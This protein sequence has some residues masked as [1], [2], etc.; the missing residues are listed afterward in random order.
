MWSAFLRMM[1][2]WSPIK[3]LILKVRTI[4]Q[5]A[6]HQTIC[7]P[8]SFSHG[9]NLNKQISAG[10]SAMKGKR[11]RQANCCGFSILQG[12]V[13]HSPLLQRWTSLPSPLL[14]ERGRSQGGPPSS[15]ASVNGASVE[16][17]ESKTAA[18][19][20]F[21]FSSFSPPAFST[22]SPSLFPTF[23]RDISDVL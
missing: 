9:C 16:R 20:R 23:S 17:R 8:P 10:M 13:S 4:G 14:G 21:L 6:N 11:E 19:S 1:S 5:R 22:F 2:E 15:E 12:I 7:M 18:Q 3:S